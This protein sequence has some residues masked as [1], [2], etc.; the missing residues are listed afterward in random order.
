MPPGLVQ[1]LSRGARRRLSV[2]LRALLLPALCA[3][4]L[5]THGYDGSLHQEITFLAAK[6]F[7]RCAQ[8]VGV[9]PVTPLQVRYAARTAVNQSD[10]GWFRRLFRWDYFDRSGASDRSIL[11][12]ID[13]R[14][15]R[16]FNDAARRLGEEDS[17]RSR[18]TDLG[19]V[20]GFI[21]DATAPAHAVPVGTFRLWRLS[22]ADRF[23][24]FAVDVERV[25]SAIAGDCAF[26]EAP[27]S[28]YRD[29]LET[30]ARDT[31]A[32]VTM[33]IP[34]LPVTWQAFWELDEDPENFGEYG[35][36]GNNFGRKTEF[37]CGERERCVL[38]ADDPLYTD[39]AFERHRTAVQGTMQ[40]MLL[41]QTSLMRGLSPE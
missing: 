24:Q 8:D 14:F 25:E 38:L 5:P 20:I 2:R 23:D 12:I 39:F 28:A 17:D 32:A 40:A 27:A 3:L 21:Q 1:T 34:G 10:A 6:Q 4:A 19:R 35:P 15:M 29:I 31:I 11:G 36:A 16:R 26:F 18:Y 33:Q 37:R 7:N 22:F 41:L 30:A 9:P 13:T